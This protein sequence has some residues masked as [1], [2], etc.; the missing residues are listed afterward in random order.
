MAA[1]D[2]HAPL[3]HPRLVRER[4]AGL[5]PGLFSR[6]R[7]QVQVWLE[8]LKRGTLDTTS[9]VSLHGGFLEDGWESA[10]AFAPF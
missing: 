4:A 5:G 7:E 10:N 1:R 6:H 8:H 3:F 9:E 2:H